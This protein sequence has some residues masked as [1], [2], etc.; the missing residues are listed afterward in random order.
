VGAWLAAVHHN[1]LLGKEHVMAGSRIPGPQCDSDSSIDDGT[2][3]RAK[4][5]TP[6][7]VCDANLESQ[8]DVSTSAPVCEQPPPLTTCVFF[9]GGF[10]SSQNDMNLW[11]RSAQEQR[12]DVTFHAF[13]YPPNTSSVPPGNVVDGF[14]SAIESIKKT[15]ADKIFIVGHSSGCAIANGVARRLKDNGNIALVALDG[16]SPDAE[17]LK[18]PNTQVWAAES[19]AA[20]SLHFA[21]LKPIAKDKFHIFPAKSDC[22]TKFALHFSLVNA[23]ANDKDIKDAHDLKNGYKGCVANLSWLAGA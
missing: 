7:P 13:P 16:F 23:A 18:R 11:L 17:Q 9:F 12:S 21:D 15:A 4:S 20:K 2:L 14:N 22:T 1:A 19:G 5:P 8:A 10:L 6:G 3:T